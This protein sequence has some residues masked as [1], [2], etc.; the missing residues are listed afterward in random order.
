MSGHSIAWLKEWANGR[1][2][3]DSEL[4]GHVKTILAA[5]ERANASKDPT[6]FGVPIKAI[7]AL[8]RIENMRDGIAAGSAV[9]P[10]G[11]ECFDDWAA[12][13]AGD[14]LK[15][16]S[17]QPAKKIQQHIIDQA[18]RMAN[19]PAWAALAAKWASPAIQADAKAVADQPGTPLAPEDDCN[20]FASQVGG[21]HYVGMAIQPA[22]YCHR[23]KIG[24]LE[25]DVISYVSRWRAKGGVEDLRKA[26]HTI[27]LILAME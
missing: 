14:A 10:S 15:A 13:V 19:D 23:N 7:D 8:K 12:D 1:D 25:G 6:L 3:L 26:R 20:P 5:L 21:D 18:E 2:E 17:D 16:E 27:D 22:E 11:Y 24:K 9:L 4:N